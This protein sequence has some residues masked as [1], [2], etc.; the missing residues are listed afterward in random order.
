MHEIA[1]KTKSISKAIDDIKLYSY[2][3]NLKLVGVPQTDSD[4]NASDT[5]D[6]CFEVFSGIGE[7]I[8]ADIDIA[9]QDID[10]AHQVLT[11]NQNG[12]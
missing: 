4:E 7:D 10:I 1:R 11:R 8:F 6:L 2:Q 3:Y 9:H 5:V 12:L